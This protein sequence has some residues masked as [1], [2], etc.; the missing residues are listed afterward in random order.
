MLDLD[1]LGLVQVL[2][3]QLQLLVSL[4]VLS[5]LEDAA[6]LCPSQLTLPSQSLRPSPGLVTEP[7]ET[8]WL[9]MP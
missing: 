5:C 7:W 9:S 8:V 6:S 4:G 2:V 1:W 3:R